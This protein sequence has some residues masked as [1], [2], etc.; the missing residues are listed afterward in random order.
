M[1]I[2]RTYKKMLRKQKAFVRENVTYVLNVGY[3][4]RDRERQ[5]TILL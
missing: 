4:K 1:L 2:I 5:D 3:G